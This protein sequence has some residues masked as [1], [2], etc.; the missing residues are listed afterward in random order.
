MVQTTKVI[1]KK[2]PKFECT[3]GFPVYYPILNN[4][5]TIR[6]WHETS[7][8]TR[9]VYIANIP[10]HPNQTDL[11]NITQLMANDGRMTKRWMN[12]YGTEPLER[13]DR[14]K[15]KKE[16]TAYLGRVLVS[17]TMLSNEKPQLSVQ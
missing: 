4:K 8:V 17:L 14:T 11:F 10:E 3:M 16:G 5:I 1:P 9:N 12:L 6:V 15:R 13:S 7:A 2:S